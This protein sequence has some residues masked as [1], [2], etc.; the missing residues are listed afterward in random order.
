M[1]TFFIF[2]SFYVLNFTFQLYSHTGVICCL[3][4]SC[5]SSIFSFFSKKWFNEVIPRI[6]VLHFSL[7]LVLQTGAEVVRLYFFRDNFIELSYFSLAMLDIIFVYRWLIIREN[8]DILAN[9]LLYTLFFCVTDYYSMIADNSI[10]VSSFN[11]SIEDEMLVLYSQPETFRRIFKAV[12]FFYS[13]AIESQDTIDKTGSESPFDLLTKATSILANKENC[14]KN[15]FNIENDL[16]KDSFCPIKNKKLYAKFVNTILFSSDPFE[17]QTYDTNFIFE[18][19]E[20]KD[21]NFDEKKLC[22][23]HD[24]LENCLVNNQTSFLPLTVDILKIEIDNHHFYLV[25]NKHFYSFASFSNFGNWL[26]I[27]ETLFKNKVARSS[28]SFQFHD[29]D[30]FLKIGVENTKTVSE[31]IERDLQFLATIKQ[32][33]EVKL[34][35]FVADH[36]KSFMNVEERCLSVEEKLVAEEEFMN[37]IDEFDLTEYDNHETVMPNTTSLDTIYFFNRS[38]FKF[39]ARFQVANLFKQGNWTSSFYAAFIKKIKT[40]FEEG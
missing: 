36:M 7:L 40:D 18:L 8:S 37:A 11:K 14:L 19:I 39:M 32:E 23:L 22:N 35:V 17:F 4:F 12:S 28:G 9:S 15:S 10:T 5:V 16:L 24:Y 21:F 2:A 13:D 3:A 25:I 31:I 34:M 26:L 1:L 20:A 27:E 30:E 6:I 29:S 38:S 33:S